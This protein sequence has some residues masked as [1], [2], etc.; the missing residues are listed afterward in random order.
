MEVD[1]IRKAAQPRLL[2]LR[3]LPEVMA[4]TDIPQNTDDSS[5][6][7]KRSDPDS[8][9]EKWYKHW[10][11][12]GVFA[13]DPDR[14][15]PRFSM[16]IPP[17]NVTGVL[18]MGH[19]LNNTLQDIL[20]RYHKLMGHDCLWVPGMDHAGI[21]TQNV[22]EKQL[23][24]QNMTRH[25]LGRE[26]FVERVWEWKEQSGGTIKNQLK[27]IG[28]A[29]DWD[30]ERFTMDEQCSL[31][32]RTAFKQLFDDGLIYQASRIINWC[33]RC[34]TALSDIEVEYEDEDGAWYHI[35]Y[36]VMG[37]DDFIEIATTRPETMLGDSAV[38]VNPDDERY[39]HL[40]GKKIM[41]PLVNREMPLITDE[42]VDR[43]FGTGALKVT[44][45]HD[46]ND[47]ELGQKHGLEQ[48]VMMTDEGIITNDYPAYA[49]MDRFVCRKQIVKD[50]DAA[51][52][53]IK[54]EA[55]THS[56]GHCYR[57]SVTIEPYIS[58]QWFV[59]MKTLAAP[60]LKAV[61]E[62]R[63][64]FVPGRWTK[65]YNTWLENIRDWCISRQLWWGHRIPVWTCADCGKQSC[66]IEDV[67]KCQHCGSENIAQ[68][69][70]VL[71]TWFSSGLW[72]LST[73]GWPN[74]TKE[75]AA[76][77]PTSVLVTGFDIIFFWVARMMFFGMRFGVDAPF[78]DVFIHGLVRDETGKK[79]SKSLGNV[80]DPLDIVSQYGADALRFTFVSQGSM[81][82]DVNVSDERFRSS[83]NF[84]NKLWNATRFILMCAPEPATVDITQLNP[85]DLDIKDRWILSRAREITDSA[86]TLMGNYD[87]NEA[88]QAI[89]QFIW[90]DFCDWY[91]EMA[92]APLRG[93]DPGARAATETIL[94]AVLRWS[95]SLL[96]PYMPFITEEIWSHLPGTQGIIL[97]SGFP[98]VAFEQDAQAGNTIALLQDVARAVR[99]I[100]ANLGAAPQE[101]IP[102]LLRTDDPDKAK[103]LNHLAEHIR[104]Q[105][106]V[107][108]LAL[109]ADL[110]AATKYM[111]GLAMG[112]EVFVPVDEERTRQE[113]ARLE[114]SM[115]NARKD[116]EKVDKKLSSQGFLAK[117]P[118][119]VV[120]KEKAK[121]AELL[122]D[123][124]KIEQRLAMLQNA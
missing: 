21:A 54:K 111:S 59:D 72:P 7:P 110:D 92:K 123:I 58:L 105:A 119:E 93:D 70:D 80:M 16:V 71:D 66:D 64:N 87:L 61:A 82:Q 5:E 13:P 67:A 109:N 88:A 2:H 22:V 38:A 53:L 36:P 60:A 101:K 81:G 102:A 33:P 77:Y 55:Y 3:G 41:L 40:H 96:H 108:D 122:A 34:K 12:N 78:H 114:K 51:G 68:D 103:A 107:S 39:M 24:A 124:G 63:T 31:A 1:F 97:D 45:A 26:K 69:P 65:V 116:I 11:E 74:Q 62:G 73:L 115:A 42:Y 85:A 47:F 35:K 76:Y 14:D 27:K 100:R 6:L 95:L 50:L 46:P 112:V 120:D 83:R 98:E 10:V 29:V 49:G 117:A 90:H 52:L 44:P 17:P 37:T 18:H 94:H 113:I 30:R 8:Y 56:V 121:Q 25:D 84:C 20:W 104:T 57:C 4:M 28:V 89:Y 118:P 79:M 75:L 15:A 48:I 19:A 99:D 106:G 32:V 86:R 9:E 23:M 43:T 91:I